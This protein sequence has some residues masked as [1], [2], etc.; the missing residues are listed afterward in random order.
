MKA[1]YLVLSVIFCVVR[2]IKNPI[3]NILME[4]TYLSWDQNSREEEFVEK[5]DEEVQYED[6]E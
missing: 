6:E 3:Y 2:G 4:R 5:E 1:T